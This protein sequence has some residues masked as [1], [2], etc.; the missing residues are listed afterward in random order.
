MTYTE[1]PPHTD[2]ARRSRSGGPAWL[3]GLLAV[4]V[5]V[6]IAWWIWP[7]DEAGPVAGDPVAVDGV[8]EE[9]AAPAPAPAD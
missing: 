1:P 8:A 2:P 6:G 5:V 4:L 7:S 3:W 9:P